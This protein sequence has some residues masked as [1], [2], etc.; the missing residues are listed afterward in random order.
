MG[1]VNAGRVPREAHT[2]LAGVMSKDATITVPF[3]GVDYTLTIA[4]AEKTLL[5]LQA[6]LYNAEEA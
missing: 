6:A 3:R 1:A 5:D 2:C 4:E